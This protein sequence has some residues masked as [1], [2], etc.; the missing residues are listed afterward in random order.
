M[1]C[2]YLH[3]HTR[4]VNEY[5]LWDTFLRLFQTKHGD[6]TMINRNLVF[7][8][9]AVLLLTTQT[10]IAGDVDSLMQG[11]NDCHGDQGVSQWTDVPTIAGLAEFVHADA[12]YIYRD[13]ERPCM[14]SAYRQGDTSR[15]ETN[16]CAIAA[17]LSD[18]EIDA[19]AAA[20]AELPYVPAKQD[21]DAALA[22]TG[23]AI[24]EKSCDRCHSDGGTNPDDEAGML[25]GQQL[26]Y[27]RNSFE[28]YAAGTREQ[29]K[30]MQEVM[31]ELSADDVEAL[32]H[33]YASVQ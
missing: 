9:A 10:G 30:K 22:A 8:A 6:F 23:K 15:A 14:D 16:M 13:K 21:F 3:R 27:L 1:S 18:D 17:E 26:G 11:C 2:T 32:L 25:G 19:L 7:S 5:G 33:Y 24:H 12:L 4:I 28:E 29:P 20:Y 31:S